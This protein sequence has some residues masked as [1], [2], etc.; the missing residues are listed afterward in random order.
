MKDKE[1]TRVLFYFGNE[2]FSAMI[3]REDELEQE[4]YLR[5]VESDL[6]PLG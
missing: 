2:L 4:T 5:G 6:E 3:G 1:G